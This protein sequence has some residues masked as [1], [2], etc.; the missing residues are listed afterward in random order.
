V[1]KHDRYEPVTSDERG[2]PVATNIFRC[3]KCKFAF[4]GLLRYTMP[5]PPNADATA[6]MADEVPSSDRTRAQLMLLGI[7]ADMLARSALRRIV[8][9]STG[10]APRDDVTADE[11]ARSIIALASENRLKLPPDAPR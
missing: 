1:C 11:L 9:H 7:P 4:V 3:S 8:E 5:H 2:E 6:P 10:I